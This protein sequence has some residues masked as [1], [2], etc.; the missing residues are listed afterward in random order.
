MNGSDSSAAE[1]LAQWRLQDQEAARQGKLVIRDG[2]R[3]AAG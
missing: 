1:L 3:G 2:E